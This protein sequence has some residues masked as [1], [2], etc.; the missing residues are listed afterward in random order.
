MVK[1]VNLHR[2]VQP[3]AGFKE[4]IVKLGGYNLAGK[5]GKNSK[6]ISMF[7]RSPKKSSQQSQLDLCK[8]QKQDLRYSDSMATAVTYS[9][10]ENYRQEILFEKYPTR[11]YPTRNIL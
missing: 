6:T 4:S 5:I 10:F 1:N 11:K 8:K 3:T 7:V 2:L 9:H